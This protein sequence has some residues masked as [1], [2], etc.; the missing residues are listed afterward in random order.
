M[1]KAATS[2]DLA[3][4][5]AR[6]RR[7]SKFLKFLMASSAIP[8]FKNFGSLPSGKIASPDPFG[9]RNVFGHVDF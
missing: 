7:R 1:A 6:G 5:F 9:R 4:A 2:T 3:D 8:D